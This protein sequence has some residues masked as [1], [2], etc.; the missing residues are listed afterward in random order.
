MLLCASKSETDKQ[1]RISSITHRIPSILHP[2]Q[3]IK[4]PPPLVNPNSTPLPLRNSPSPQRQRLQLQRRRPN[5][6]NKT[7]RA[8]YDATNVDNII[9]VSRDIAHP[10]S[11]NTHLLRRGSRTG[12]CRC[13]E[14]TFK[15]GVQDVGGGWR[16]TSCDCKCVDELEDEEAGKGT[17]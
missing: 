17:A 7:H 3:S 1:H 8:E 9:P 16:D 5:E 11:L 14:G 2:T 15:F 13:D 4:T 10:A 12:E 6:I